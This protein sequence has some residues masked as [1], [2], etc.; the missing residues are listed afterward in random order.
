MTFKVSDNQY[1]W[2]HPSDSWVFVLLFHRINHNV[3]SSLQAYRVFTRLSNRRTNIEV[4]QAGLLEP[5]PWLKCRL[6]LRLL[7]HS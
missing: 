2:P 1:G 3:R 4:A 7:A 5:R 6:K